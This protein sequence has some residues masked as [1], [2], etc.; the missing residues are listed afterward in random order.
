MVF[1][2]INGRYEHRLDML[3][4]SEE[5]KNLRQYLNGKNI[6]IAPV[7]SPGFPYTA[8]KSDIPPT[9]IMKYQIL[10]AFAS[11]AKGVGIYSEGFFDALDMKC[12]AEAIGEILP[13]ENIL[14]KGCPISSEELVDLNHETF[15]KG[16]KDEGGNA[17]ILVSEYS[18]NAKTARVKYS[19]ARTGFKVY[20]LG[21]L[22]RDPVQLP[23]DK[24]KNVFE[25]TLTKDRARLFFLKVDK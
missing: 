6:I 18:K 24:E 16:I 5:V 1:I 4:V 19:G 2:D 25:L 23:K 21:D 7:L 15:V 22:S 11:G 12:F 17:V 14:A 10:E 13:V 8:F 20:D 9:G 3:E